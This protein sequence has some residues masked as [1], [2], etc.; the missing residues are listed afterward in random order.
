MDEL[1]QDK[2][3]AVMRSSGG[4][5]ALRELYEDAKIGKNKHFSAG[6]RHLR[7]HFLVGVPLVLLNV[8]IGSMLVKLADW[9]ASGW[10]KQS[11]AVAAFIAAC[12]GAVQTLFNFNK[13]AEGHRGIANRYLRISRRCKHLFLQN[14]DLPLV[15]E[16]LW[17]NIGRLRKAYERV[18]EDAEAFPTRAADLTNALR[19]ESI[20]PCNLPEISEDPVITS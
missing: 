15:P 6:D 20:T 3:A 12:L 8:G 19:A 18:N 5:P 14:R 4:V 16:E 7:Y 13:S 9:P 10:V 11:V 17:R 2:N 1:L